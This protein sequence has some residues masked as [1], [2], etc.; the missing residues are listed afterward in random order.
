MKIICTLILCITSLVTY[1]EKQLYGIKTSN[2]IDG[3]S[4]GKTQFVSP[5][6]ETGVAPIKNVGEDTGK[7]QGSVKD[8][9]GE[10]LVGVSIR[11]LDT[12][13]GVISDVNGKFVLEDIP[14]GTYKLEISYLGF[15]KVLTTITI[16]RN[17]TNVLDQQLKPS[18]DELDELVILG[19]SDAELK[20]K[21][22]IQVTVLE[23]KALREQPVGAQDLIKKSTGVQLREQGGLGS[24]VTFS[25]NGLS[26]RAVRIY[27][28]G[29]PVEFLGNGLALNALPIGQIERVEVYKG[30][31]P[32][33][34]ATDALGGGINIITRKIEGSYLEASYQVGSFNTHRAS[35]I[36]KQELGS[37]TSLG[38][39][40]FY[41]YSD[42]D[43]KMEDIPNLSVEVIEN[44]FGRQ[45]TIFAE[46][47]ITARRFHNAHRSYFVE[48][49]LDVYDTK[50]ADRFSVSVGH[51]DRRDE[52]Q[53][54]I[55]VTRR[56]FG[57][58]VRTGNQ[59]LS[60]LTYNKRVGAR[61]NFTQSS[62][63]SYTRTFV[64]DSTNNVYDWN[65]NILPIAD[66]NGA[67]LGAPTNRK[68]ENIG[69][70]HRSTVKYAFNK[71]HYLVASNF[72]GYNQIFGEDPFGNRI[73]VNETI[74]DPNE[75]KSDLSSNIFG[76]QYES[77]WLGRDQLTSTLFYKNYS[78]KAQSIDLD[79]PGEI[80]LG[81][82]PVTSVQK[83]FHGGG[84]GFKYA[85][86]KKFF[87]RTSYERTV[88]IPTVS[89][90]FG[91]FA[92]V[93]QN[94]NLRPEKS[95]NINLGLNYRLTKGQNFSFDIDVN[96]F[97]RDQ[98]DLI[99]L[100][101]LNGGVSSVFINEAQVLSQGFELSTN[102]RPGKR[103][104][105]G[106]N[107]TYQSIAL[108]ESDEPGEEIF[109]GEQIPNFPKLFFNTSVS[110]AIPELFNKDDRL[111]ISW[112]YFYVDPFAVT[113][114]APLRS[115]RNSNPQ[116]INPAQHDHALGL[117]YSDASRGLSF[118]VRLNNVFNNPLFDN[119]RAPKPGRNIMFKILYKLNR[120]NKNK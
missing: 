66:T 19:E 32:V 58:V 117:I 5:L 62:N 15:E 54:G 45:D 56:P 73:T 44:R 14:V 110:Y 112:D 108:S 34:V 70:S 21:D 51:S 79:F 120:T 87:L 8:E 68:G 119:F 95:H 22:P 78:Y 10:P 2:G 74:I 12:S 53:N 80:D 93:L 71:K 114:V 16:T 1:G 96:S 23:S 9:N 30:V 116:N 107:F 38:I 97:L 77:I 113:D 69:T 11:L 106:Y 111:S 102:V 27:V 52:V 89:E 118:S 99:R 104:K 36:A 31:I 76:F 39:T 92:N 88:R 37:K 28:D 55:R 82:L 59:I 4:N 47:T 75:I 29:T 65:G 41:N 109:I 57:E 81:S 46:N 83:S 7:L 6:Q 40:G 85:F 42:N 24:N 115:L 86:T 94:F 63:F 100:L 50:W 43:Y 33:D 26:G 61:W 18:V 67:E 84:A 13:Y 48:G 64:G 105:I 3:L 98:E 35:L 101:P 90:F 25:L 20:A 60:A 49:K 103:I 17:S 72:F 91:N